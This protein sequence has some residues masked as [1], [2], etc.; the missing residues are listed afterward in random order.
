VVGVAD[1]LRTAITDSAPDNGNWVQLG[2]HVE[3]EPHVKNHDTERWIPREKIDLKLHK[4]LR[5]MSDTESEIVDTASRAPLR[6][7]AHRCEHHTPWDA[8]P[9]TTPCTPL[10]QKPHPK[11]C[12]FVTPPPS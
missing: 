2:D 9:N 12:R 3:G 10:C 1:T 11:G 6:T 5:A 8:I 4:R 7:A